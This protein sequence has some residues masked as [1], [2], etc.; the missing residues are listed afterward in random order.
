[1]P[2]ILTNSTQTV[3]YFSMTERDI[4]LP[5]MLKDNLSNEPVGFRSLMSGTRNLISS[6]KVFE[7]VGVSWMQNSPEEICDA[8][9]EMLGAFG[10]QGFQYK[11]PSK[12]QQDFNVQL[13]KLCDAD[14][15]IKLKALGRI[16]NNFFKKFY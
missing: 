12:E 3:P 4:F 10:P 15:P 2:V 1:M 16:S 7:N 8:V 9:E 13:A 5:R 14:L 11:A 6:D